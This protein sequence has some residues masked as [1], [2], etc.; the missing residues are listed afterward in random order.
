MLRHTIFL[1]LI[2]FASITVSK[3]V[4]GEVF[5]GSGLVD[6]PTGQVLQTRNI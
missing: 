4:R 5:T 1:F 3:P 2:V 6:I